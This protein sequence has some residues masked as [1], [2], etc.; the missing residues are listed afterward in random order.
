MAVAIQ[1]TPELRIGAATPLFSV[2]VDH[3][4]ATFDV[5]PD[6]KRFLALVPEVSVTQQPLTVVLNATPEWLKQ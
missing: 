6:G 3:A 5:A 1:T 4:W 2:P